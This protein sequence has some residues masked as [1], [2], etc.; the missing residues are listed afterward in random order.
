[1]SIDIPHTK[2]VLLR[3]KYACTSYVNKKLTH[4]CVSTVV[5]QILIISVVGVPQ[6]ETASCDSP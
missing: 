3:V 5:K 2:S 4:H 6:R 1:M